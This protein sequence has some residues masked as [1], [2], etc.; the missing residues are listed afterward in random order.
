[1]KKIQPFYGI[2]V[3]ISTPFSHGKIDEKA[4]RHHLSWLLEAGI[5]GVVPCGTTGESEALTLEE[6]GRLIQI[7]VELCRNK[8]F[9][10]PGTGAPTYGEALL[11]TRQAESLGADGALVVTPYYVKADEK[12]VRHYYQALHDQ[13]SIPLVLYNNPGRTGYELP[14]HLI[15]EL[16]ASCQR[17][18]GLKDASL[19]LTRP[20]TLRSFMRKDF[21]LL[22]GEDGTLSAFWAQGGNGVVSVMANVAPN[23]YIA[24]YQSWK[25]KRL[26]TF[27]QLRDRLYPLTRLLFKTPSPGPLKAALEMMGYGSQE[28]RLPLSP[29]EPSH[30]KDLQET[31]HNL[32]DIR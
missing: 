1:M 4:F 13:T 16:V 29:L 3:A 9:V 18:C 24:L 28:T 7:S 27:F 32:R 25:E 20:L 2:F 5:H 19:D 21:S 23:A 10:V 30:Q 8:A 26:E 17:I 11:Y 14:C 6:R 22:S 31:L 15:E 12:G